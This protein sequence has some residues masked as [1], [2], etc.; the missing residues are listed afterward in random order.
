MVGYCEKRALPNIL[1]CISEAV[2][3]QF[4]HARAAARPMQP[5]YKMINN[6]KALI[7]FLRT[8]QDSCSRSTQRA[9]VDG[10]LHTADLA[11]ATNE[12]TL[13]R[14][15]YTANLLVCVLNGLPVS[16]RDGAVSETRAGLPG[17]STASMGC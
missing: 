3:Q 1:V 9:D 5:H 15:N 6:L 7:S 12:G 13:Q 8:E 4:E 16:A 17:D 14:Y 2:K 11:V 10:Q